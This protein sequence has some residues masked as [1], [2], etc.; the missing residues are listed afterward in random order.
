M[1]AGRPC[2]PG[3]SGADGRPSPARKGECTEAPRMQTPA[4]TADAVC[5]PLMNEELKPVSSGC[6]RGAGARATVCAAAATEVRA[7]VCV[8]P[9]RWANRELSIRRAY[10]ERKTLPITA[11][12][13]VP[14]ASRVASFTA[15]PTPVF[16]GGRTLR[17]DSV[18]GAE[19]S[20]DPG[21][22]TPSPL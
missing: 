5:S 1:G 12:P 16:A 11:T 2:H 19:V 14:P 15:E 8:A 10:R 9:G 3:G 4:A 17:M 6:C 13:S 22:S 21:P 7:V 18:G 20:P